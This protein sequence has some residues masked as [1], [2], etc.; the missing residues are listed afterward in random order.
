MGMGKLVGE[1][2]WA[3]DWGHRCGIEG[4]QIGNPNFFNPGSRIIS[5]CVSFMVLCGGIR[6][7]AY[8]VRRRKDLRLSGEGEKGG[9]GYV[10]NQ[11]IIRISN[12]RSRRT[13]TFLSAR[14]LE[15]GLW[16]AEEGVTGVWRKGYGEGDGVVKEGK[17]RVTGKVKGA[18]RDVEAVQGKGRDVTSLS[19]VSGFPAE[20]SKELEAFPLDAL[21]C[22]A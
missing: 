14:G 2:G 10:R 5:T 22:R 19:T 18:A 9:A 11:E 20:G 15:K 16:G 8:G 21:S 7:S 13:L 4:F 6:G 3:R 1:G 17:G 12:P